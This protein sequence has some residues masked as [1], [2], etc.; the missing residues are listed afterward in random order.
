MRIQPKPIFHKAS[1]LPSPAFHFP[2]FKGSKRSW[3]WES[4]QKPRTDKTPPNIDIIHRATGHPA[5]NLSFTQLFERCLQLICHWEGLGW[6][7]G[8]VQQVFLRELLSEIQNQFPL[9]LQE[10]LGKDIHQALL[11]ILEAQDK[12][13]WQLWAQ[14]LRPGQ[15]APPHE[16]MTRWK[17]GFDTLG[18]YPEIQALQ[19]AL[20]QRTYFEAA[21]STAAEL[22]FTTALGFALVL[23]IYIQNGGVNPGALAAYKA[24]LRQTSEQVPEA[25]RREAL[26]HAVANSAPPAQEN[27]VRK[28]KLTL[29]HGQGKVHGVEYHLKAWGFLEA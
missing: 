10:A 17:N 19:T 23:D 28:R 11:E 21:Q 27:E 6:A 3:Q 25:L 16:W 14:A 2:P 24:Y 4:L 8:G 12:T 1:G 29:A 26:A 20:A 22:G 13:A 7:I 18:Q 5:Q 15:K 9:L